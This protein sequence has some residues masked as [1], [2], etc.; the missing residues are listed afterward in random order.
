MFLHP[1]SPPS[2]GPLGNELNLPAPERKWSLDQACGDQ[3][4]GR[5]EITVGSPKPVS[6]GFS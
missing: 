6:L 2:Y 5:A 3:S 1:T 4:G